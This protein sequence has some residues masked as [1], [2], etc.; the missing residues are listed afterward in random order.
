MIQL[1]FFCS[2]FFGFFWRT[3]FFYFFLNAFPLSV[4]QQQRRKIRSVGAVRMPK[5][6]VSICNLSSYM[7]FLLFYFPYLTTHCFRWSCFPV[8]CFSNIQQLRRRI[9]SATALRLL[10]N[11]TKKTAAIIQSNKTLEK[12]KD[13]IRIPQHPVWNV[14]IIT[15]AILLINA[16]K[17]RKKW[18]E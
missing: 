12:K 9:R 2:L 18:W 6:P 10:G 13:R 8:L 1:W 4:I 14:G 5:L 16:S 7:V 17:R 15:E 11:P 3:V